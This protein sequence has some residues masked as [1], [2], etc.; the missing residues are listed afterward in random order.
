MHTSLG[1]PIFCS[2]QSVRVPASHRN[3]AFATSLLLPQNRSVEVRSAGY[4]DSRGIV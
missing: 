2:H 3:C 1:V 4:E